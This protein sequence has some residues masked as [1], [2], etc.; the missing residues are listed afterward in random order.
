MYSSL[1]RR[2]GY[3]EHL[4]R[5]FGCVLEKGL[6]LPRRAKSGGG[7][8]GGALEGSVLLESVD[9]MPGKKASLQL[10]GTVLV[11][12]ILVRAASFTRAAMYT[13]D[14]TAVQG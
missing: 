12:T 7:E 14:V 2:I 4:L 10:A 6:G 9:P 5:G 1:G 13:I 8:A 3:R 11:R